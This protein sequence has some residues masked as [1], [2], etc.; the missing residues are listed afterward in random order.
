MNECALRR[1]VLDLGLPCDEDEC[2]FW[3]H[4]G[5]EG[6]GATSRCAIEY[7]GML[8]EAGE[9]L[10]EWLLSLKERTDV[11]QI[12]GLERSKPPVVR[13]QAS[14]AQLEGQPRGP[15]GRPQVSAGQP[16]VPAE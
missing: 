9:E 6:E 12:L 11:A 1:H 15:A 2:L 10:A 7:F 8:G 3:T 5:P 4:L 14:V 13:P 16:T